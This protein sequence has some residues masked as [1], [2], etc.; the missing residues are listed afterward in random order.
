MEWGP[1]WG[2]VCEHGSGFR[3]YTGLEVNLGLDSGGQCEH[4]LG[5]SEWLGSGFSLGPW[6]SIGP[7]SGA[8]LA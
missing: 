6:G 1:T 4:G 8:G 5:V 7:G 2:P 3:V